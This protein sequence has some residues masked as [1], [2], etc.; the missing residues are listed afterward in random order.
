MND[1]LPVGI[2]KGLRDCGYDEKW[3]HDQVAANPSAL[4]LGQLKVV[5]RERIQTRGGRLDMLLRD[6]VDDSMYEVELMLG[7]TDESHII[8]T[9]EYWDNERRKYPQREHFAV[10]V[11]ESITRRFFNVIQLL[12]QSIPIIAVQANIVEAGGMRLLHFTKVM[13]TYDE[14]D[15]K[16]DDSENINHETTWKDESPW[17]IESA[18]TLQSI[19]KPIL[20]ESALR[21]LK[22][23]ISITINGE[24]Y[25]WLHHR[26][27]G[28]SLLSIWVADEYIPKAEQIVSNSGLELTK[29]PDGTIRI[30]VDSETIKSKASIFSELSSLVKESWK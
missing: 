15:D 19:I 9:I 6:P 13:D 23:Y 5:E 25:F 10:L 28:K 14:P 7:E 20:G 24:I 17:T 4:Q 2:I 12:S 18:K 3:L 27:N 11:A 8:R 29:K 16:G 21:Y 30:R 1:Q 22:F 26:S